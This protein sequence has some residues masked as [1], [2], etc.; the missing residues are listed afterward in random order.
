[1]KTLIL[2]LGLLLISTYAVFG[3]ELTFKSGIIYDSTNKKLTNA[4][5]LELMKP[6]SAA[7][8]LYTAASAQSTLGGILLGAGAG[9]VVG[10]LIK[11]VT[12]NVMY[13]SA[14]TYIGLGSALIS[15]PITSGRSKKI[16]KSIEAYNQDITGKKTAFLIEKTAFITN[17][18]GMGMQLTF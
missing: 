10:D 5:I 12:T 2:N 17:Q 11:S 3:Q 13:P 14:L 9:F 1:M 6:H 15:I 4:E 16:K 7:L 18:N 8:E